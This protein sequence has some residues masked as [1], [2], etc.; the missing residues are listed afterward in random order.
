MRKLATVPAAEVEEYGAVAKVWALAC[1]LA[2]ESV[3]VPAELEGFWRIWIYDAEVKNGGHLQFFHNQGVAGVPATL[4]AL[5]E[6]GAEDH[7]RLLE[8][9][10][11]LE[12]LEPLPTVRTLEEYSEMAQE[13]SFEA[14]DR[15]YYLLPDVCGLLAERRE[16]LLNE[17][18]EV[19]V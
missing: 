19:R 9:C 15:A 18:V 16:V 12:R 10:W 6:V 7:A 5:R 3:N 17:V 4:E 11:S 8:Q 13:R 2:E 1:A 14:E